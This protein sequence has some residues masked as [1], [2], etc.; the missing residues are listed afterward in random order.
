[1]DN[2]FK[3]KLLINAGASSFASDLNPL[4]I[5]IKNKNHKIMRLLYK[6]CD[7]SPN[8]NLIGELSPFQLA[9]R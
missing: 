2:D 6:E 5:A 4:H 8:R 3:A 1:M 9:I 7:A